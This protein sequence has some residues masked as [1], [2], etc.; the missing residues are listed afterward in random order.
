M[1]PTKEMTC[2]IGTLAFRVYNVS[3]DERYVNVE[4]I[5]DDGEVGNID[6]SMKEWRALERAAGKP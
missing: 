4:V 6:C 1:K 3:N 5:A 2:L